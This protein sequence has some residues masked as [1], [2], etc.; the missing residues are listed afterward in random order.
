MPGRQGLPGGGPLKRHPQRLLRRG[1]WVSGG[2]GGREATA[3]PE[4]HGEPGCA[5]HFGQVLCAM[6]S[7]C[8]WSVGDAR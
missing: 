6:S 7:A 2:C 1:N 4:R 8:D 3:P 5:S